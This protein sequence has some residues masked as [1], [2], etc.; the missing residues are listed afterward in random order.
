MRTKLSILLVLLA[1]SGIALAQNAPITFES[2]EFG[3]DW[4]W[5][6]FENDSNPAVEIIA[7]P[8]TSGANTSATV[9]SFTALTTGQPWAG[10]ESLHG[11]DIG[12]FSF[13][14]SNATVK[15]MVWKSVISDVGIKFAEASGEAQLETK[16]ANTLINEWEELTF[17]LS[18][19]IGAGITGIVDQIII[20]P[21]FDLAGRTT[22]NTVYIDNVTFSEQVI[23]DAA[24]VVAAPVP[25]VAAEDVMS[26]YSGAYVD[27]AETNFNPN[28]GQST[29]VTVGADVAGDATLLYETLNYQGTNLGGADG[30]DQDFSGYD[31][32]HID[33]WTSNAS[34]LNFFLISRTTGEQPFALPITAEEWVSV[35]IPLAHFTDLGLG[36]TDIFQFKVDGGDGATKVWFDNWYFYMAEPLPEAP[37]VA[38]PV[39]TL[40]AEDV[41]SV[42]SGAYTDLAE[43]N[44]NPDWGQS[45]VVTIDADVAGDAT[46]LYETLNYQGTNLGGADGV[47]QDFSEY[48]FL[49][50]DF[51]TSNASA[52]TLF[53]I[54]R[55][56]G[57]QPFALPIVAGEWVSIDIPLDHYA[58]LG[59]GLTDIFQFKVDGGDGATNVWFDN[60]YFHG[61]VI[62]VPDPG[63]FFSE[64]AEGTSS[65]KYVEIYNPTDADVDL[66]TYSVQGTN[67]GTL[68]GDAGERDLA[69]SGILPAGHVYVIAADEASPAILELA[70]LALPYESPVHH[71][72]DDG[73]ALLN[74]GLIIDAIGVDGVDPGDGWAVA[75]VLDAT[76]DH[77]LVRKNEVMY[78]NIGNWEMSAGTD[79]LNS[80]WHVENPPTAD[81]LPPTLGWHMMPPPPPA[82]LVA[83]PAAMHDAAEV[84][85]IYSAAYDNLAETNFNPD[86]GQSTA[87]TLNADV[88]GDT[89]HLLYGMLNYQ[90]TNLGGPEG[91]DQDVSGYQFLHIDFWSSN[92][93]AL[94]FYLISRGTGEQG[95][96]LPIVPGEWVSLDI[97]LN[98]FTNLGLGLT[99]IF[100]FKVD[101]GDGATNVWFD[102]WYFHTPAPPPP[103]P[104]ELAGTWVMA[105]MAGAVAVGPNPFDGSWWANSEEDVLTRA[106]FF[107]DKYVFNADG[108]FSNVLDGDTWL[109]TWQ[110]VAGDGCGAPV[111]PH[112]G[113][114]PA[115]W[116]IDPVA[117]TVTLDGVGS[118]LGIPKAFNGGELTNP[119]DAPASITYE[120]HVNDSS[121]TIALVLDIGGGFWTFTMVPA[122]LPPI[123]LAGTWVM[124]PM[125][126]AVAVGPNPF[127]GSW[128]ANSEEDVLTRAC[129]FDDKYV[130]NA[131]GSFS[132]MLDGDTWLETWQGVEADGCGAPVAPHDGMT[133]A[134]WS[135]DPEMRTVT[136][137]GVGSYL[138]IPKAF[139][140]GEL[141]NPADAPASITYEVHIDGGAPGI[142][143]VL[144]IGGGFW[145]FKMVPAM[146]P[147]PH[148]MVAAP[149]P[150]IEALEVFSI[151]S[152]AYADLAETNFNPDWGQSTQVMFEDIEGN[153]TMKYG[154]LNYQGTNLG[155]A[156]GLDQDVSGYDFIH[157]DLWSHNA[158]TLNFFLIS[159]TTGEQT[160]SLPIVPGE[161]ASVDIP[162]SYFTDLGLGLTDIFQFKVDGGDGETAVWFD[163]WFFHGLNGTGIDGNMLPEEFA[164]SQNYPNPFNPSTTINYSIAQSG[165]VTLK[166]YN[167][168]GQ[169][170]VTL[171][172]GEVAPGYYTTNFDA[173]HLATGTYFYAL[174]AGKNRS[175]K[176]MVLI[177]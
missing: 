115:T 87:V 124:A 138:G 14:A 25:M 144:D 110:G 59:L 114:T 117:R 111:A 106:C 126:G 169:E 103:P 11:A 142:S 50:V 101:G 18:G 19:S 72:G 135:I 89:T 151:F 133:P 94:N 71:N 67:N 127:D 7:N 29:A 116:S 27:L 88:A 21:D 107:D 172:D 95:F 23:N 12:P 44:F 22:D 13:S 139:N 74:N 170:V 92:A 15:I 113:M 119:A 177:K 81:Y 174:T 90:G 65:N 45:T 86:W 112:D 78:G 83:A 77:T 76:K 98:Y 164:L 60:W 17:D 134:T 105:P 1:F 152:D 24:P 34:A 53:L 63:L 20:F 41:M 156:D 157:V 33:F 66:S 136:L 47:D 43:T 93:P 176:K 4:T 64:Y 6:A 125:A 122:P 46:L 8:D 161:W 100:Q 82:P 146:L 104:I 163:N 165:H 42:Y 162:L 159:R 62:I 160:F 2:G 120:V 118:Y 130:F 85:S 129:F 61:E 39:P 54:S 52:L 31:F 79:S 69:L 80:Q 102:N 49:H 5:S 73:I 75:G 123:E 158:S 166:L 108:S 155:S 173:S 55:T 68:W 141:T 167:I 131:D 154:N 37:V 150:E 145:T 58:D 26:I 148:P 149:T 137:N 28:W 48:A 91:V 128:W 56:T 121:G 97:P 3:A 153:N 175:V 30:V 99:D 51:W 16:V 38:A 171:I 57:E 84:M 132:N 109:E 35:D 10:F 9:A 147:P 168:T 40:P 140:G 96:A 70:D 32:I 36:L 143:L